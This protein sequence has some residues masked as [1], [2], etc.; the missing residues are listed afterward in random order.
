MRSKWMA[1]YIA[2]MFLVVPGF[3][4]EKL[5]PSPVDEVGVYYQVD[6]K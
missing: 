6:G 5:G 3:S 2:L 4:Q 1:V